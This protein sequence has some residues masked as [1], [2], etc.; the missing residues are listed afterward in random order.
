VV[1]PSAEKNEYGC[2]YVRFIR[3]SDQKTLLYYNSHEWKEAPEEV[4]GC[5]MAAIQ[6][7][8]EES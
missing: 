1:F 6:N 8:A 2:D 4:M 5:I 7:G 3:T